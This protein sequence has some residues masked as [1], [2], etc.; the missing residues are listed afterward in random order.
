[1][2]HGTKHAR[3]NFVTQRDQQKDD[4]EV[5]REMK[6]C[7]YSRCTQVQ[8]CWVND[9]DVNHGCFISAPALC[10]PSFACVEQALRGAETSRPDWQPNPSSKSSFHVKPG[11]A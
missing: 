8:P 9:Q 6:L 7:P 3:I 2:G 4:T 1:M 10:R 5:T 11:A